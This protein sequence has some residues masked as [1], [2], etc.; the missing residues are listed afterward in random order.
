MKQKTETKQKNEKREKKEKVKRPIDKMKIAQI[1][2]IIF[3]VL[4][5]VL[6]V[7][8]TLIYYIVNA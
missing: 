7:A 3:L 4:A 2:I 5:M 1:V 6:S 8:G